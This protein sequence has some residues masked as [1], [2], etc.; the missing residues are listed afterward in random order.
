MSPGRKVKFTPRTLRVLLA[1]LL[2]I[3]LGLS[4]AGFIYAQKELQSYAKEISRKKIDANASNSTISTLQK[5]QSQLQDYDDI[6]EK[7]QNLRADDEFPEFRVIDE[8]NKIASRN[9][10]PVS[11]FSYGD[12]AAAA[13]AS[14][15]APAATTPP[16]AA[17]PVVPSTSAAA[18]K[19]ISLIV[20]FGQISDYKSY[21]Q[22]L[23]DIEQNIPKM[24]VK[25]VAVSSGAAAASGDTSSGA[26]QSQSSSGGL[27]IQPITIELFIQ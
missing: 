26:S 1:A 24:K 21:L 10:I 13:D 25:S 23:Y 7:I 12:S 11:S 5:V 19:T 22:F 3:I 4:T 18:G 8:V 14:G 16:A 17:T 20:N 6:K 2:I 27:N 9:N 15:T